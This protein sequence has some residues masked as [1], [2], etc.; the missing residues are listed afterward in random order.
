MIRFG[1]G[2]RLGVW[3]SLL[4]MLAAG[5]TG[6]YAYNRSHNMLVEA[7][8]EKL[9]TSTRVLARRFTSAMQAISDD[10]ML[11]TQLTKLNHINI[12]ETHEDHVD[13]HRTHLAEIFHSLLLLHPEYT[14]IR[15]IGAENN[16]RE[17]I[18]IDRDASG[19]I[20]VK[21]DELQEKGHY[22]YVFKTLRLPPGAIYLSKINLNREQGAHLGMNLPTIRVATPV[23]DEHGAVHGLIVINVDLDGLFELMAADLPDDVRLFLTNQKGDYLIH[24]DA[25]R[26]FGFDHGQRF[27]VQDEFQ[28]TEEIIHGRLNERVLQTGH[29]PG[30][31]EE[32]VAAF[33]RIPLAMGGSPRSVILGLALPLKTVL[34]DA[35]R[36][37]R[38]VIQIVIGF[39][40]L[41][42]L[43]SVFLTRALTRPL[44]MVVD[45]VKRF[46][47][48]GVSKDL[49]L[50][51]DDEIGLLAR[52][53]SQMGDQIRTQLTELNESEARLNQAQQIAKIG[54]WELDLREN[55]LWWSPQIYQMFEL[56][57]NEFGASYE[58]FLAAIHAD[59]REMV[60]KAYTDSLKHKRPYEITHRLLMKD[61]RVKYV[62]E[63]CESFFDQQGAPVRSIGTVQDVT[64]LKLADEALRQSHEALEQQTLKQ[65]ELI[66]ELEAK[67][68]ELERFTYTVSHDLKSPLVTVNG[69][70][71][72]LEND[73]LSGDIER[74][75]GDTLQIKNATNKMG[76]LLEDLLELS[77][78]GRMINPYKTFSLDELI[79]EAL[80]LV[81]GQIEETGAQIE[82]TS[83]FPELHADRQRMLEV[84]QNLL[85]NAIK[86]SRKGVRPKVEVKAW[87]ADGQVFCCVSDN[88]IGIELRYHEKVFG[89]F[90]RLDS[91]FE[92]T[93]IGLA[94]V[95]RI[96]EVQNGKVWI[97]PGESG[98]GLRIC[99]AIPENHSE[100][101]STSE[102][103]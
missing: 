98:P 99:F 36:L 44:H 20:E 50:G 83:D 70:L 15:L 96:I 43:L 63:K 21:G 67:N 64:L 89:L 62:N 49:P 60:N 56:D 41:A 100:Q 29:R 86:F 61:G 74:V 22:P 77:R 48:A 45:A 26:S 13:D 30:Q 35:L 9:L 94:L 18:R 14:Q 37:G 59:D 11:F 55:R 5:M 88:G 97:E 38:E 7:A 58:A 69:F 80:G 85:D 72:L 91:D 24:P 46:P 76:Q 68:A 95:K 42:I 40:L 101:K 52:S 66:S 71:G 103:S 33:H 92:G 57:P 78:V 93:G 79:H 17:L 81:R 4:G 51:R 87:R 8:E 28:Q 31:D 65:G 16:G 90:E 47:D 82:I 75:R 84:M 53:F 12:G 23:H 32:L 27:R 73:L 10:V 54:S 3:L 102:A 34:K 6:Y 19:L 39:S 25:T 2:I 1:I